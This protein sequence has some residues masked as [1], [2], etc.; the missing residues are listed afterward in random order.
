MILGDRFLA[1]HRQSAV[2][3][4]GRSNDDDLSLLRPTT[5][6]RPTI[7]E[8]S[9]LLWPMIL[10]AVISIGSGKCRVPSAIFYYLLLLP[11]RSAMEV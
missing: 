7:I 4:F 10:S 6:C 11:S 3:W 9:M 2:L 8:V 1:A 5:S